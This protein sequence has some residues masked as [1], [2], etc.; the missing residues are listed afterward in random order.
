MLKYLPF[1]FVFVVIITSLDFFFFKLLPKTEFIIHNIAALAVG[2]ALVFLSASLLK[3]KPLRKELLYVNIS[4]G[5]V[6]IAA[7]VTKLIIGKCI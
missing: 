3:R 6:M 5:L 1:T 7:H 4:V 2:I